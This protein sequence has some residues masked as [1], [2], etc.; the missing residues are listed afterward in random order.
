MSV[1]S[2]NCQ[3]I[4][5]SY[6]LKSKQAFGN[7]EEVESPYKRE[8]D[9]LKAE[10]D[11]LKKM[12]D[13]KDNKLISSIGTLGMGAAAAALSFYSF[14]AI[15]PMAF[16]S[17]KTVVNKFTNLGF[18]KKSVELA[19]KG[20]SKVS[21]KISKAINNINPESKMG[22]VKNFISEK[23][24][25]LKSKITPITNKIKEKFNKFVEKHNINKEYVGNAANN[26]IAT[27]VSIPAGVTAINE[28]LEG[29][30]GGQD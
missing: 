20:Y 23:M 3:P 24:T 27:L 14:K 8:I 10:R 4:R 18:V 2:L 28:R 30:D 16:K 17:V 1:N 6:Q 22:K 5:P 12:S 29:N 25:W 19:K 11:T 7:S 13:N 15:S 9:A 26:T 21:E